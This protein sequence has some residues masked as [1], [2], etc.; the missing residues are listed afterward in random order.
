[1][2]EMQQNRIGNDRDRLANEGKGRSN[3]IKSLTNEKG[4]AH[5]VV[6]GWSI[7]SIR[8]PCAGDLR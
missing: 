3:T 5:P 7:C 1:M 4:E 6:P 2:T 8:V